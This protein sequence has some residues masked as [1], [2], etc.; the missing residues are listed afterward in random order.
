MLFLLSFTVIGLHSCYQMK[1]DKDLAQI[2]GISEVH[3]CSTKHSSEVTIPHDADDIELYNLC[4]STIDLFLNHSTF[5]LNEDF[6]ERRSYYKKINWTK[7][8]INSIAYK[9]VID[10]ALSKRS[11]PLRNKWVK[12]ISNILSSH[13][14]YYSFYYTEGDVAFYVLDLLSNNL[15]ILYLR[16]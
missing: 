9:D 4:N 14:S 11:D 3:I 1:D 10:L 13:E 12:D 15:Y 5:V 6:F 16:L 8:P 7:S 2:L